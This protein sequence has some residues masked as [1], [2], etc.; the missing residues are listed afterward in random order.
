MIEL[1]VLPGLD[2]TATLLSEFKSA[3]MASFSSVITISYPLDK[4]LN[5][6]EL[7]S[8][9]RNALPKDKP[10]V[11]LGE[12]FS[13]PIALSIAA[14]PPPGLVG[15]VLSATFAKNPVALLKPFASLTR[16][17][18]VR[19][20]P[21]SVLSWFLL[22]NWVTPQLKAS[23][24]AALYSVS[25]S[26]LRT[27]ASASLRVDVT[28][29]LSNI[30]VPVLYLRAAND[31]LIFSGAGDKILSAIPHSKL[32]SIPGPHLL[33]QAAPVTCAKAVADFA[34]NLS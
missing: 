2:G 23:L 5:Y 28:G 34:N 30:S 1:V 10:F 31:R 33:L 29:C 8:F 17:A 22:G 12:S 9:A 13:G 6:A 20:L 11:L 26:V 7:E 18:P 16:F 14:N 3:S 32:V 21:V 19:A 24:R 15:L 25:P 27:R 4:A